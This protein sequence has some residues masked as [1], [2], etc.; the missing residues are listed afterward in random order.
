MLNGLRHERIKLL[1]RIAFQEKSILAN[2]TRIGVGQAG[3]RAITAN[4]LIK[5]QMATRQPFPRNA[6]ELTT[7]KGTMA[8]GFFLLLVPEGLGK[9]PGDGAKGLPASV[10]L[11]WEKAGAISGWMSQGRFGEWSFRDGAGEGKAG[12][13]P[14]FGWSKWEAGLIP[15]LPAPKQSFGLHLMGSEVTDAGLKE[16]APLKQL[17]LLGL[18][19]T[20]VTDAGL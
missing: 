18:A 10:R 9:P 17:E 13:L 1:F 5:W 15:Q 14:V 3:R 4:I 20:Q 19:H 8:F 11:A 7:M 2:C 16:L 12:E 6:E